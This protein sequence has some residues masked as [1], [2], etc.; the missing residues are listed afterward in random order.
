MDELA[1]CG[2]TNEKVFALDAKEATNL[3]YGYWSDSTT[4]KSRAKIWSNNDIQWWT[5]SPKNGDQENIGIVTEDGSITSIEAKEAPGQKS[6]GAPVASPAFNLDLEPVLFASADPGDSLKD[7]IH[8]TD[9]D[10]KRPQDNQQRAVVAKVGSSENYAGKN[11]WK[12]TLLDESKKLTLGTGIQKGN[13]V[14]VPYTYK[15]SSKELF[16]KDQ[17][18][19][20]ITDGEYNSKTATVLY[21]GQMT[22]EPLSTKEGEG[23]GTFTMP[24]NLPGTAKVYLLLEYLSGSN[25]TDYASEPVLLHIH[26]WSSDWSS[27]DTH[28]WHECLAADCPITDKSKKD[29][30]GEHQ[31]NNGVVTKEPTYGQAGVKTYSCKTCGHVIRTETL[32]AIPSMPKVKASTT[33]K[34]VKLSWKAVKGTDGYQVYRATKKNGSYKKVKTTASKSWT[35]K[36]LTT[37]KTYYYKVRTYKKENGKTTYGGFSKT[38][39]AVPRTKA[40][41]FKL[42]AGN[43]KMKVKWNKVSGADGYKIYR[44]KSKNGKYQMVKDS[45]SRLRTYTSTGLSDHHTYYYKMR[46]YKVVKGKKVYSA[47]TNVKSKRT[48]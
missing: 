19:V 4:A 45:R 38:V 18:S 46:S 13:I 31:E 20:M 6:A 36:N 25:R 17:I 12:L 37:G 21:Y 39:K 48:K 30:Y 2:L 42:T 29:G 35:N 41:G 40:P 32:E 24:Q 22:T 23:T 27:D 47:Y 43:N 15:G 10:I 9:G 8:Y 5:R 28:H 16:G 7:K 33:Y 26:N 44:A 34:S 3:A 11:E 1:W 14:T